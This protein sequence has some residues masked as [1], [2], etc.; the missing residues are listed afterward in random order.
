[1]SFSIDEFV[2]GLNARFENMTVTYKELDYNGK[3]PVF[4]ARCRSLEE[5]ASKWTKLVDAV[6]FDFQSQLNDDF[7]IW[8][9]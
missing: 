2:A 3:I 4:F 6:A 8:N 7:Q 9:I 1:M 5:L